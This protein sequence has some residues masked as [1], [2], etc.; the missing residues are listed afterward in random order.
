MNKIHIPITLHIYIN[1][2]GELV[3]IDSFA[4]LYC[5]ITGF[6]IQWGIIFPIVI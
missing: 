1:Q 5:E 2:F 3:Y 4:G 6:Q